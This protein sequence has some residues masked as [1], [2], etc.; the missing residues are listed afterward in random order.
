[1]P[2]S[3]LVVRRLTAADAEFFCD[4]RLE[5]LQQAPEAY[6]SSHEV[7]ASHPL[8]WFAERIASTQ[9]FRAFQDGALVGIAHFAI[10]EG[11]K[12]CHNGVLWG[13]YVRPA[14]RA[15]GVGRQLCAE[16]L[17]EAQG[18]VEQ[19]GLTVLTTNSHARR[20]YE[21]LGF[22]AWGIERKARKIGG[23]YYDDVHMVKDLT[24]Q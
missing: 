1:M 20:L 22:V 3:S 7:E 24:S 12:R 10:Q 17:H 21:G 2:S 15:H 11:H 8:A 4:I 19:I 23:S 16:T 18:Q 6:G 9:V 13:V 14:A 5:S